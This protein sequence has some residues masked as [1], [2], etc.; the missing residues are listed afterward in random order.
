MTDEA[1]IKERPKIQAGQRWNTVGKGVARVLATDGQIYGYPVIVELDNGALF[2]LT[3]LGFAP[4]RQD[5]V[6]PFDLVDLAPATVKRE[7]ALYRHVPSGTLC[8][9]FT[10]AIPTPDMRLIGAEPRTIEFTLLPGESA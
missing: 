10:D 1:Q 2:N 6:S 9:L 3:D 5:G 7:V 8:P 4:M